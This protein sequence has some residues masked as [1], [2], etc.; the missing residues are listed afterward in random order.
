MGKTAKTRENNLLPLLKPVKTWSLSKMAFTALA[1]AGTLKE[2]DQKYLDIL[3]QKSPEIKHSTDLAHSFHQLFVA[4]EEGSLTEWIKTAS[5]EGSELKGFAK[6]INQDYEAVNQAVIS[7]I[8]NGQVEG[9]VNRLKTIKRN[10]YGR[11]GFDLLRKI[12]LA[13]SGRIIHQK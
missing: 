6:G 10:M 3:L 11:A 2:E 8:S 12:V 4:K 9:Q 7:T 13:H 1:K 5:A